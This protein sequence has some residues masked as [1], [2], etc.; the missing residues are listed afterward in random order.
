[1][2]EKDDAW[3]ASII[4][5]NDFQGTWEKFV[6]QKELENAQLAEKLRREGKIIISVKPFKLFDQTKINGFIGRGIFRFEQYN[7]IKHDG[8]R[9]FKSRIIN[10]I[11]GKGTNKS[12]EKSRFMIQGYNNDGKFL[13]FTQSPTIQRFSQRILL[14]ITPALLRKGMFLWLRN[15]TQ[16]Y[17]QSENPLQRTILAEL[18][19]QIRNLHPKGT[20][21]MVVKHLY[22]VAEA[23]AYW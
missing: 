9:I 5:A 4:Q 2:A 11:K 21:I 13:M 1:V 10:E 16:A 3:A 20:I 19:K 22:G 6:T 15:V 12:Y 8:I 17:T 7:L 14:A 18:P 23:G